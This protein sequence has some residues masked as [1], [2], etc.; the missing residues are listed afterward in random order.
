MQLE[1]S[2]RNFWVRFRMKTYIECPCCGC[3]GAESD[4]DGMF[5]DGQQ[6]ICLCPGW[7]SVDE[8]GESWINNGDEPCIICD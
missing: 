6:L 4:C 8:D 1:L 2:G 7:V 3:E 5:Y